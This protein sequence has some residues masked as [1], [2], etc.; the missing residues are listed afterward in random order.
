MNYMPPSNSGGGA[1]NGNG[2]GN[3][4]NMMISPPCCT[5]STFEK[6]FIPLFF[7]IEFAG[8]CCV[9]IGLVSSINADQTGDV[10]VLV[11]WG[12]TFGGAITMVIAA[13]FFSGK[14]IY[15]QKYI[16]GPK[17][18][19]YRLKD[20]GLFGQINSRLQNAK[21]TGETEIWKMLDGIELS[22][23]YVFQTPT[24]DYDYP[25]TWIWVLVYV[26]GY[27]C[28]AVGCILMIRDWVKLG[29]MFVRGGA[30]LVMMG[31]YE[32]TSIDEE[33]TQ[34]VERRHYQLEN[35]A[36]RIGCQGQQRQQ[37]PI[38]QKFA[39]QL[40]INS[41]TVVNAG[42]AYLSVNYQAPTL[43]PQE[44]A[45]EKARGFATLAPSAKQQQL[46]LQMRHLQRTGSMPIIG[47]NLNARSVA[48][49]SSSPSSSS[50]SSSSSSSLPAIEMTS[51]SA[52]ALDDE[53]SKTMEML[54]NLPPAERDRMLREVADEHAN[55][56][57]TMDASAGAGAGAITANANP[58]D[59]GDYVAIPIQAS[60]S[61]SSSSSSSPVP[62][63]SPIPSS[64]ASSDT[65]DNVSALPKNP[66]ERRKT[67]QQRL[68][69]QMKIQNQRLHMKTNSNPS[70][71][72]A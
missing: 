36:T 38:I 28:T 56:N 53:D 40:E 4:N 50:L 10:G 59:V 57:G 33:Y 45:D 1:Y 67:L 65:T 18:Q 6:I 26:L 14:N 21:T 54:N 11:P 49:L 62:A 7:F 68:K 35:F 58:N 69:E 23:N 3:L 16:C 60:S 46:Q 44:S 66:A 52:A 13:H 55:E 22:H 9:E 71:P 70:N 34:I 30:V 48:M 2:N 27:A 20:C 19:D 32:E 63:S 42:L 29:L 12:V 51:L 43:K 5:R 15:T 31:I 72:N 8:F 64:S 61:S 17:R 41:Y 37:M 47:A 24:P 25:S 39:E